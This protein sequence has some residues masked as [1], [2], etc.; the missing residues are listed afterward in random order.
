MAMAIVMAL[1]ELQAISMTAP[2]TADTIVQQKRLNILGSSSYLK[3]KIC[4]YIGAWGKI[5]LQMTELYFH[6][7]VIGYPEEYTLTGKLNLN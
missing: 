3:K 5:I 6:K 7:A 4:M 1:M 2:I